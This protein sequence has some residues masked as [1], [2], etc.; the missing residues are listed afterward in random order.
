MKSWL[1]AL[2]CALFLSVVGRAGATVVPHAGHY[3]GSSTGGH[4]VTFH[5]HGNTVLN[6][7]FGHTKMAP[8][9]T[10]HSN[11]IAFYR[12]T[13]IQVTCHWS[14]PTHVTGTMVALSSGAYYHWST[15]L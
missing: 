1:A 6:F 9:M 2:V 7:Y 13:H 3:T 14:S 5:V 4:H 11:S 12:N 15:H 8:S 10:I